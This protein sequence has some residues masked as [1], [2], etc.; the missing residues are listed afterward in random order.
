M[1]LDLQIV[2]QRDSLGSHWRV[3]LAIGPTGG[4]Q[5]CVPSPVKERSLSL[6]G[7]SLLISGRGVEWSGTWFSTQCLVLRLEESGAQVGAEASEW[8]GIGPVEFEVP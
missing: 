4:V 2:S 6:K 7:I 8:C 1:Y 3:E 5:G